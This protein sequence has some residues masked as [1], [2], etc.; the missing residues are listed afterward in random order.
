M[1][2]IEIFVRDEI[3]MLKCCFECHITGGPIRNQDVFKSAS[4]AR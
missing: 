3:Q 1:K 2:D 4:M